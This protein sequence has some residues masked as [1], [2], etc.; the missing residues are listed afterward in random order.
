MDTDVM[1]LRISLLCELA[2]I[3]PVQFSALFFHIVISFKK[4]DVSAIINC[5]KF[6]SPIGNVINGEFLLY[7][8]VYVH[9]FLI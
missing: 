8:N 4:R 3:I 5:S 7:Y 2:C 6:E 9:F 1:R